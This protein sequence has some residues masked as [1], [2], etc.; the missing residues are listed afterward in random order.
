MLANKSP[1]ET[2]QSVLGSLYH[3]PVKKIGA[4][5]WINCATAV[6][7]VSELS[8]L[9]RFGGLIALASFASFVAAL[10]IVSALFA[11]EDAWRKQRR[12]TAQRSG[13]PAWVIILAVTAATLGS[14]DAVAANDEAIRVATSIAMREEAIATRRTVD[15]TLTNTRGRT[16]KR[17]AIVHKFGGTDF[18]ATRTTF[19]EPKKSR[20]VSFLS[21]D[22]YKQDASDRHWMYLPQ[23]RK[24]RQIPASQRGKS[25][26][27]TDF[28]YEDM[29]SELKFSLGD[30]HFSYG[31][32]TLEADGI[33][34]I[35]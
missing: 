28:S 9:T 29:Q 4:T 32:R 2:P 7:A 30:W 24:V 34:F 17:V 8:T 6:L 15:M 20:N 31:G 10:I 1:A 23:A 14:N 3:R 25:F 13:V 16:E 11:L 21:H 22:Y 18:R 5:G 26:L 12:R 27:G 19:L 35:P 33:F